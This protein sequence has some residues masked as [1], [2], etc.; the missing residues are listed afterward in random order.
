M[1]SGRVDAIV[2]GAGVIGLYTAH[3]IGRRG[4]SVL[5]FEQGVAGQ[6]QSAGNARIFRNV[7]DTPQMTHRAVRARAAWGRLESQLGETLLGGEGMLVY[8]GVGP[9]GSDWTQ[10][11]VEARPLR[12]AEAESLLPRAALARETLLDVRAGV[13][14]ADRVCSRLA[15]SLGTTLRRGRVL[16]LHARA[17]EVEVQTSV[18][19]WSCDSAI[20][21][22]GV[23]TAALAATQGIEI[24]ERRGVHAQISFELLPGFEPPCFLDRS[25]QLGERAYGLPVPGRREMAV[26][27]DQRRDL[28]DV[29]GGD[30]LR[31]SSALREVE[32]RIVAYVEK[33]FPGALGSPRSSRLCVFTPLP[34]DPDAFSAW[35]AGPIVFAAG[36]NAFKFAPLIAAEL[37][38]VCEGRALPESLSPTA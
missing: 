1:I 29:L 12:P 36:H 34:A 16:G 27:L 9:E 23:H 37:A 24:P 8:G 26:G 32:A 6:G 15:A 35:Q 10:L 13:I 11:G 28:L 30:L 17:S 20:V 7:H 21:A 25:D 31:P 2:V 33:A 5:C 18:G 38:D 3:E 4:G 22:A 19:T 14:R